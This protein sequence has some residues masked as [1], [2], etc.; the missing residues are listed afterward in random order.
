MDKLYRLTG[1]GTVRVTIELP[2]PVADLLVATARFNYMALRGPAGLGDYLS[3]YI[4]N[5]VRA[6]AEHISNEKGVLVACDDW[7]REGV[8][9]VKPRLLSLLPNVSNER[10]TLPR[11]G[12]RPWWLKAGRG[13]KFE[14][15]RAGKVSVW[16]NFLDGLDTDSEE[17]SEGCSA[18][19]AANKTAP[20]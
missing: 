5:M 1:R 8:L 6:D 4:C 16:V 3:Y 2:R 15:W 14:P 11:G 17:T 10:Y 18:T 7:E 13:P 12:R 19:T 20:S 9:A